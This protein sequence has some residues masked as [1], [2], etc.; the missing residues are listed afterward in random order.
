ML[1]PPESHLL[2]HPAFNS[3]SQKISTPSRGVTHYTIEELCDEIRSSPMLA[4]LSIGDLY[5]REIPTGV[6][7]EFIIVRSVPYG[8]NPATWIRI[9]RAA[10]GYRERF[11]LTSRYPADDTVSCVQSVHIINARSQC[12]APRNRHVLVRTRTTSKWLE[13]AVSEHTWCLH[14]R[15]RRR[16]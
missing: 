13:R 15:K 11:K 8:G 1:L 2:G 4:E 12:A 16:S 5:R 3:S 10:K 6:Q 7:H 14:H 9:D